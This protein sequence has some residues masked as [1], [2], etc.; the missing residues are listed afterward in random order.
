MEIAS[1]L[2]A[3]PVRHELG[4]RVIS[5]LLL[6]AFAVGTVLSPAAAQSTNKCVA[7]A[8]TAFALDLYQR[9]RTNAGN[10]FF[11]PYSISTALAMTYA[12]ARGQTAQEM[13]RVLHLTLPQ[14]EVPTAFAALGKRM[15]EIANGKQVTLAVANSLWA[16]RRYQFAQPFLELNRRYFGA[17]IELVDF[18][19]QST[20]AC[21]QINDWVGRKT[22]GLICDLAQPGQFT[23]DTRLALCNAIYFKGTWV[24][25][26]NREATSPGPFTVAKGHTVT[27]PM[28]FQT[29]KLRCHRSREA[30]VFSLPYAGNDFSMVICLPAAVDGLGDIENQLNLERCAQWLGSLDGEVGTEFELS[31]PRFKL[32]SRL[33]LTKRLSVMGMRSAFDEVAADFS[34]MCEANDLFLSDMMHQAFVEVN[35]EGTVA[36]A[37][38][39]D[40]FLRRSSGPTPLMVDHPFLFLIQDRR[41]GTILFLG[42][43]VDPTK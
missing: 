6:T 15:A 10:L 23:H 33:D 21:R 12:G 3:L 4:R 14:D 36:A 41:S 26:F 31:L 37:A 13:A 39:M 40:S 25:R 28:M 30:T 16:Q 35:E 17:E 9:E 1:L 22:Q 11:S 7:P 19:R 2:Q 42:R 29:V 43:V 34:G 32:S 18:E 27:V 5:S 24:T 8:N 38:S 20:V